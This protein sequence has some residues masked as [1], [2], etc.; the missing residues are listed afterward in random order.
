MKNLL[1]FRVKYGFG[2]ADRVTISEEELEKAI[3]AQVK[4]MPVKL[5]NA[6]ING[7]N[8]ISITPNYH[9]YTS[10]NP[11][12]EPE[13]PEDWNQIKR[14]CPS[15]DGVL[16]YYQDRVRLLMSTG[17]ENMIGQGVELPELEAPKEEVKKIERGGGFKRIS[18]IV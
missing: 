5:G 4:G 15:F 3:Y 11:W 13:S 12:Y 7:R 16:D 1:S 6:Y 2:T 14:D 17:R 10:W 9:K 8:I 18:D